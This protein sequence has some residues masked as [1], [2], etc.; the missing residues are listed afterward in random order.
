[1]V[2]EVG[3]ELAQST[4]AWWSAVS[5]WIEILHGQ[6]LSRLGPVEPGLQFNDTTLW[7]RLYS[8]HGHPIREGH[9]LPVGSGA[10]GVVWP[11]YAPIDA[12]Q[13]QQCI[14]WADQHGQPPTEWLLIRDARS[15][16]AGHDFRR[17]VLD[18]GLAA[19][20]AVNQLISAHLCANG[21]SAEGIG[22][23]LRK[24][25]MLG[26]RC[27]YWI[28][29]CGGALPNNYERRL[30]DQRNA[31]THTGYAPSERDVRD[32][33]AVATEIVAQAAPLPV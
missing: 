13:L 22:A 10:M 26:R 11:N 14:T 5:A 8:L 32:A 21:E 31:A 28:H 18:A 12:A 19:E 30:L 20:L 24:H 3:R 7:T 17:A 25:R 33:I 15:L 29:N 2:R 9:V 16:C 6:D 1:M 23:T 4:S 27:A